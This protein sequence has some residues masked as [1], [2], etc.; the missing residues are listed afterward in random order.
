MEFEK[1]MR[2]EFEAMLGGPEKPRELR[3]LME[4]G[5]RLIEKLPAEYVSEE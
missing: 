5:K 2:E 4:S 1:R 3:D